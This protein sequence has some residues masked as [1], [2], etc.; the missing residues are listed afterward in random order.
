[1][2][3]CGQYLTHALLAS[4]HMVNSQPVAKLEAV[5]HPPFTYLVFMI[6]LYSIYLHALV[7]GGFLS[8]CPANMS[9][10]NWWASAHLALS[11]SQMDCHPLPSHTGKKR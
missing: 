11:S 7:G 8:D 6:T 5:C 4:E 10:L 9:R 1:M 3:R 2:E